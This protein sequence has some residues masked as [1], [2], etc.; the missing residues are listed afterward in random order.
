[1]RYTKS[2]PSP[3][4]FRRLERMHFCNDHQLVIP[5]RLM[6]AGSELYLT[7][8]PAR[9]LLLF[10][11]EI[12]EPLKNKLLDLPRDFPQGGPLKRLL[13]GNARDLSVNTK[14]R[15]ALAPELAEFAQLDKTAYWVQSGGLVELWSPDL[16]CKNENGSWLGRQLT[17]K[18]AA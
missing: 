4:V 11:A 5:E 14:H 8:D 10:G 6:P 17:R 1:M 3:L 9:C 15:L 2:G 16:F 12:W 7:A 18:V 13:I